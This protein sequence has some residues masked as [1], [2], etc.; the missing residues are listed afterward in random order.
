MKNIYLKENIKDATELEQNTSIQK[1]KSENVH[2]DFKNI[3][4]FKFINIQGLTNIKYTEIEKEICE[5]TIICLTETQKKIDH[6][7]V[8]RGINTISSMR[9][10]KE[11]REV[12]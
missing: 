11:K 4:S 1:R 5:N 3:F 7:K 10:I 8:S 9:N 6:I 12:V 2:V